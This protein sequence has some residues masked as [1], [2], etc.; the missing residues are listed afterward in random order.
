V[1]HRVA[2]SD[3]VGEVSLYQS[4][5][6][7][8]DHRIY[9]PGAQERDRSFISVPCITLDSFIEREGVTVDLI[10]VDTQGAEFQ[11]LLGMQELLSRQ[12]RRLK[13]LIEFWPYGLSMSGSSPE[14]TLALLE[15]FGFSMKIVR[16]TT[17]DLVPTTSREILQLVTGRDYVEYQG[18]LNLL[19]ERAS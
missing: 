12:G 4:P 15:K 2:V 7:Q 16:E 14:E 5:D 19:L 8:G 10:K 6:N 17:K 3:R 13:L 11:I 18:F 9:P 1:A